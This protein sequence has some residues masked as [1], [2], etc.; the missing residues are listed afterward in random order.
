MHK[1]SE[2]V[3][4]AVK[5]R[6]PDPEDAS[7]IFPRREVGKGPGVIC[8]LATQ[9]V[10]KVIDTCPWR[11]RT[12]RCVQ[13]HQTLGFRSTNGDTPSVTTTCA[14][15]FLLGCV[16]G[17][18]F[19]GISDY[20]PIT[21]VLFAIFFVVV[22]GGFRLSGAKFFPT[23]PCWWRIY[24]STPIARCRVSITEREKRKERKI[25]RGT[26]GRSCHRPVFRNLSLLHSTGSLS[27]PGRRRQREEPGKDCFRIS[28]V[29]ANL[30]ILILAQFSSVSAIVLLLHGL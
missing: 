7:L 19:Q 14:L 22:F 15:A 20:C 6:L 26:L 10:T 9:S 27:N 23:L 2:S 8:W 16:L 21:A 28:D 4:E 25:A 29:F 1:E 12:F 5:V 17:R 30:P 3:S 11:I 13:F 18:L 24:F